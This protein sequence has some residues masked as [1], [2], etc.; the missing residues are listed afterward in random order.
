MCSKI[1][2]GKYV[3]YMYCGQKFGNN[4]HFFCQTLSST[5]KT[6]KRGVKNYIWQFKHTLGPSFA[7]LNISVKLNIFLRY[8]QIKVQKWWNSAFH[9]WRILIWQYLKYLFTLSKIFCWSK[10]G[11]SRHEV[12]NILVNQMFTCLNCARQNVASVMDTFRE[13]CP[14]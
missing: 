13:N 12:P 8:H 14:F 5:A 6:S 11:Q 10:L 2:C 1:M 9:H 7:Q 4:F 3:N